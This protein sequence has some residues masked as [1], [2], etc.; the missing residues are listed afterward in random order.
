M[1]RWYWRNGVADGVRFFPSNTL[2]GEGTRG[3]HSA[4]LLLGLYGSNQ[5]KRLL[6]NSLGN[7]VYLL[8][9]FLLFA[10]VLLGLCEADHWCEVIDEDFIAV[11]KLFLLFVYVLL[12][13]ELQTFNIQNLMYSIHTSHFSATFCQ[14]VFSSYLLIWDPTR[15]PGDRDGSVRDLSLFIF[16]RF[17]SIQDVYK[18][19]LVPYSLTVVFFISSFWIWPFCWLHLFE[20]SDDI[21]NYYPIVF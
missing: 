11:N 3:T 20:F 2:E 13:E 15:H 4:V 9:F 5:D 6:E 14:L 1:L 10:W 16:I 21:L 7:P 18:I 19:G 17:Q 8:L 12:Y